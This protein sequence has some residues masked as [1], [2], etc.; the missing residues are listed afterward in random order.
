MRDVPRSAAVHRAWEQSAPTFRDR[1]RLVPGRSVSNA[2]VPHCALGGV[3]GASEGW[4]LPRWTVRHVAG[5][6]E[7][8]RYPVQLTTQRYRQEGSGRVPE[9]NLTVGGE[10]ETR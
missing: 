5:R 8:L 7:S 3:V 4:I 10:A 9:R 2:H 1:S 6:G